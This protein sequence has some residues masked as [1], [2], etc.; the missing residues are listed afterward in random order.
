MKARHILGGVILLVF[1]IWGTSAFFRTTIQYVS[2]EEARS[3]RHMVQVM[4]VIDFDAVTYNTDDA[5]LEFAIYDP[6]AAD[7]TVARRLPVVYY[8][9]VPGNFGQASSVVLKGKPDD[10]GVFVADRLLVKC[11]SKYQ[12]E[13]GDEYQ[14]IRKHEEALDSSGA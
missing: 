1:L 9:V 13:G 3:S 12:G 10:G 8:G 7:T 5:C 11:P 2:I 6:E 4:G 14:D